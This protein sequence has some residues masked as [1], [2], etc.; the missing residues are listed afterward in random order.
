[1]TYRSAD[2]KRLPE[3]Y[4]IRRRAAATMVLLLAVALVI[5]GLLAWGGGRGGNEETT[6][7]APVESTETTPAEEPTS[8][9]SATSETEEPEPEESEE[10]E[11]EVEHTASPYPEAEEEE[12]EPEETE[13][14]SA[15]CELQDLVITADSDQPTY[16][17]R[18]M[19]VFYMTVENPT[20]ADCE[21]DL[22]EA[23]LRFEVYDLATNRRIWSDVDCYDPV[24]SDRQTFGA[25]SS[26]YFEATWSRTASAPEQ[27]DSRPSVPEGSYFLHA[28]VGDNPSPAHPFNLS[29]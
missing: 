24:E 11:P 25:E 27:C 18:A 9:A 3:K 16:L 6:G 28:V 8:A 21:I 2:A 7:A 23:T 4:Y 29:D 10:P 20:G 12:G 19:P 26:R 13:P 1:M 14:A 5:W 15:S 17:D 22:N